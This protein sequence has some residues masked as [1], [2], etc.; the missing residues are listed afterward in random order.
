MF[1]SKLWEAKARE[2]RLQERVTELETALSKIANE[3]TPGWDPGALCDIAAKALATQ[4][5]SNEQD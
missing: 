2:V 5:S 1:I 4:E 3:P